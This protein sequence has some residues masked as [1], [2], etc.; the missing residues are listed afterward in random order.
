[1]SRLRSPSRDPEHRWPRSTSREDRL[2]L[3]VSGVWWPSLNVVTAA[4]EQCGTQ[5]TRTKSLSIEILT[6]GNYV[7]RCLVSAQPSGREN[8]FVVVAFW[9]LSLPITRI[10]SQKGPSPSVLPEAS[11]KCS[12][13]RVPFFHLRPPNPGASFQA[14][15]KFFDFSRSRSSDVIPDGKRSSGRIDDV[16]SE[17]A[18]GTEVD[19]DGSSREWK[20]EQAHVERFIDL[21]QEVLHYLNIAGFNC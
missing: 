6:S 10:R 4:R 13:C 2:A 1:M 8:S 16:P 7:M 18:L 3:S 9:A 11:L 20:G 17:G 19:V 14:E 5:A 15:V 21:P 12:L